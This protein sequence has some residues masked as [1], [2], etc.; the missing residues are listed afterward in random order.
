MATPRRD[1]SDAAR[2]KST[3]RMSDSS[4]LEP[5]RY[6]HILSHTLTHT[7]THSHTHSHTHTHTHSH[8]HTHTFTHTHTHTLT[9]THT[10]TRT[11]TPDT[12]D[13]M[14][15]RFAERCVNANVELCFVIGQC[16]GNGALF[17]VGVGA[18]CASNVVHKVPTGASGTWDPMHPCNIHLESELQHT[19]HLTS[20]VRTPRTLLVVRA[21]S[22]LGIQTALRIT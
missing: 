17:D 14:Q 10:H 19:G 6:T 21:E 11:H 1:G 3:L 8:T 16:H 20:G 22:E 12:G 2:V 15:R 4:H 18:T 7:H 9:H 5:G 13:F